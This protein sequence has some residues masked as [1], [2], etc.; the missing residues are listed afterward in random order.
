ME[1]LRPKLN[2]LKPALASPK[3]AIRGHYTTIMKDGEIIQIGTSEELVLNPAT[4]Y[5]AEFTKGIPR[6]KVL[7]AAAVAAPVGPGTIGR[8]AC[9]A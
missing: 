5:V 6:A 1:N 4:D 3:P 8:L 9:N 2:Q 7:S